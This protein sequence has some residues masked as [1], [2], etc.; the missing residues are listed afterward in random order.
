MGLDFSSINDY[1][2]GS[3]E[4]PFAEEEIKVALFDM[5]WDKDSGPDGF[6]TTF[7]RCNWDIVKEDILSLFREFHAN[8]RFVQ[9]LNTTILVL[10]PKKV[11][12]E[13]L[14]DYR[15]ISL[16][17]SLYKWIAKVLSNRLKRVM[18]KLVNVAQNAFVEGRQILDASLIAN[19]LVDSIQKKKERGVPCVMDIEKTY[20]NISWSFII[21]ILKRIVFGA[22]WVDKI[23]WCISTATF[24]VLINGSPCGFFRSS[25]G[26]R[27]GDPLSPYLFV[28]GMEVLSIL[29]NKAIDGG[30]L[31]SYKLRDISGYEVQVS[32]MLFVDDTLVF[33]EDSRDQIM[34]LS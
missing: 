7:W 14:K 31:S 26:L 8:G 29:I 23:R 2:A 17:G 4:R 10:V 13:D 19:E 22:K 1:E 6:T 18:G 24:S 20:N 25:K 27:Q 3:L 11:S 15:P 9:S 5:S 28:L 34:Y 12:S 33:C 21:Q 16:V 32:H 30:F